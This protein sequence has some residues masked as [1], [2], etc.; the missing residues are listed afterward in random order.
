MAGL[1]PLDPASAGVIA[2]WVTSR[3]EATLA[4]GPQLPWPLT[5]QLLL[6]IDADPLW[7]VLVLREGSGTVVASGSFFTKEEGRRLRIGRVI[8]DPSRRGEGWGRVL[9]EALL[10]EADGRP[11]VAFTELAV[12][13]HNTVARELY[14]KLGFAETGESR[15]VAV[16]DETW[17]ALEMERAAPAS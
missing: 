5:G 13:E 14:R 7:Q 4:G 1:E 2:S 9:M 17:L 8:V 11:A 15:Q 3:A 10:A 12:F 6:G 16:D